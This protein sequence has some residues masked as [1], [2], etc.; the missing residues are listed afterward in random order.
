MN[1]EE[2]EVGSGKL[3]TYVYSPVIKQ[4]PHEQQRIPSGELEIGHFTTYISTNLS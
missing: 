4:T 3:T 1:H 2:A